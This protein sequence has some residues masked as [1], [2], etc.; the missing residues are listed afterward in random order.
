M[1]MNAEMVAGDVLRHRTN[2]FRH[3]HRL[4][5]AIGIAKNDPARAGCV[6]SFRAGKR[7]FSVGFIAIEEML[8]I[9]DGFLAR[10]NGSSNGSVDGLEVFLIGAAERYAHMVVPALADETN[11]IG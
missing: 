11:R 7:I 1:R 2:D 4:R 10:L 8:A 6:G 3:F 9:D 5:A